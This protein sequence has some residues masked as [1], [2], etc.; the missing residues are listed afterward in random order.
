MT[1]EPYKSIELVNFHVVDTS[2]DTIDTLKYK[3]NA[4]KLRVARRTLE[5]FSLYD[6]QVSSLYSKH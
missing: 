1:S 6:S 2:V 3:R 5:N 4:L